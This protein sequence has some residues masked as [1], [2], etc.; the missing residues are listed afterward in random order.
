[1]SDGQQVEHCIGGSSH[2]NIQGHRIFERVEG[3]NT[4]GQYIGIAIF[5]ITQGILY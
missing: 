5:I 1:M 3:S 4:P 2:G